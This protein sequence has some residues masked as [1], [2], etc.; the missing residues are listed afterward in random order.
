V[1]DGK[2]TNEPSDL[3]IGPSPK[4]TD[5]TSGVEQALE[6]ND[7]EGRREGRSEAHGAESRRGLGPDGGASEEVRDHLR[8]RHHKRVPVRPR[9]IDAVEADLVKA[10]QQGDPKKAWETVLQV[11][12]MARGLVVEAARDRFSSNFGT[13]QCLTCSG[14]NAGPDVV[15][16]CSQ[17]RQCY[18]TNLRTS[19]ATPKQLRVIDNLSEEE[20]GS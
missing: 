6:G 14:L 17:L 11:L 10:F 15:A 5:G 3:S 12:K 13:T 20:E 4:G 7:R 19:D 18:F 8:G 2:N 1:T 16:T 9:D